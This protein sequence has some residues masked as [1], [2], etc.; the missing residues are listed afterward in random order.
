MPFNQLLAAQR[1]DPTALVAKTL[2]RLPPLEHPIVLSV[3]GNI[4]AG[5]STFLRLLNKHFGESAIE[6]MQEPV[7][8]WTDCRGQNMLDV[9]ER[10][11]SLALS[12][13]HR[14]T[15]R[16]VQTFYKEPARYAYTFQSFAF[17]TR[18][19]EQQKAQ[20]KPIRILERSAL[21]DYCFAR[22]CFETG[23]MNA[24]E[25]AAYQEWWSFF[26]RSMPGGPNGILYLYT[27]PDVRSSLPHSHSL[28]LT[29]SLAILSRPA[30]S[31]C[32][33]ATAARRAACHSST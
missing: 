20:V 11:G 21:S 10:Q 3:E 15:D 22:N 6:V 31:A 14:L 33:S 12:V 4:G 32:T 29:H 24:V 1:A 27:T 28:T 7:H 2:A 5:K 26:S 16:C 9:R 30:S 8:R 18:L 25:W 13:T 19:M 17:I 23:L